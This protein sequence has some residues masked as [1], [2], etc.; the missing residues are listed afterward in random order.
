MRASPT[1]K[2]Q[3]PAASFGPSTTRLD[4]TVCLRLPEGEDPTVAEILRR[5]SAAADALGGELQAWETGDA[6]ERLRRLQERMQ[7]LEEQLFAQGLLRSP[8]EHRSVAGEVAHASARPMVPVLQ[9]SAAGDPHHPRTSP[10]PGVL[11]APAQLLVQGLRADV[12]GLTRA[13]GGLAAALE[14]RGIPVPEEVERELSR[15]LAR[16]GRQPPSRG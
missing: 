16:S 2:I 5:C 15:V 13:L 14:S 4:V 9:S 11:A 6:F 1:E 10:I 7:K 8:V 12:Y 3:R